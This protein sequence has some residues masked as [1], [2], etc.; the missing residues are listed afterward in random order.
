VI[1]GP[2]NGTDDKPTGIT[3]GAAVDVVE[4]EGFTNRPR[5]SLDGGPTNGA[6]IA[7]AIGA[8]VG[9][10]EAGNAPPTDDVTS[11]LNS[12]LSG[13]TFGLSG[14]KGNF[15]APSF[16]IFDVAT[17]CLEGNFSKGDP[18]RESASFQRYEQTK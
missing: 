13:A 18:P 11:C 2:T 10:E 6:P 14:A 7:I 9:S 5:D 16:A 12:Y 4:T 1:G 17:A 3:I 15:S 8:A